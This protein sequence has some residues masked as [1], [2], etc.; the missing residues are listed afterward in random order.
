MDIKDILK[1][2]AILIENICIV[3][4]CAQLSFDVIND[5]LKINI[6][7]HSDDGLIIEFEEFNNDYNT[8]SDGFLVSESFFIVLKKIKTYNGGDK[9]IKPL[10]D[11]LNH[12]LAII[13]LIPEKCYNDIDQIIVDIICSEYYPNGPIEY[14]EMKYEAFQSA[15]NMTW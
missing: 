4:S 14:D 7:S 10:L 15:Q 5:V 1:A 13:I 11:F 12:I 3:D 9:F 6:N 2:K 8:C